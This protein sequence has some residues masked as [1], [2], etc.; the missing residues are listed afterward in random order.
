MLFVGLEVKAYVYSFVSWSHL[1]AK[2]DKSINAVAN[3]Y[4]VAHNLKHESGAYPGLGTRK[5]ENSHCSQD[6]IREIQL[7]ICNSSVDDYGFVPGPSIAI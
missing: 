7:H 3:G 4:G 1:L 6:L 5:M 2:R